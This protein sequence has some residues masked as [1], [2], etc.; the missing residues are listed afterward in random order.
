MNAVLRH[1]TA[2]PFWQ[3][4]RK[5]SALMHKIGSKRM[6]KVMIMLAAAAAILFAG[7]LAWLLIVG[8]C[9]YAVVA[10]WRLHL[11]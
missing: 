3:N 7:A 2:S 11:R 1:S 9:T 10:V 4:R 5:L 8:A 6:R